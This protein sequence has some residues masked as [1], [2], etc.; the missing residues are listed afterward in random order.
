[1]IVKKIF[2]FT[3]L[4]LTEKIEIIHL[5]GAGV[6]LN[7]MKSYTDFNTFGFEK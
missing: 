1:M 3:I 4:S 2:A 7:K 6:R 5:T